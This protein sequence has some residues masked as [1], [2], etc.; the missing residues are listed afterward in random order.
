MPFCSS[1]PK[2]DAKRTQ[3]PKTKLPTLDSMDAPI[4]LEPIALEPIALEPI[5]LEPVPTAPLTAVT[6][7]QSGRPVQ[8]VKRA[9]PTPDATS[10]TAPAPVPAPALAPAAEPAVEPDAHDAS[11]WDSS[12]D[13]DEAI[14]LVPSSTVA[15]AVAPNRV[16][17]LALAASNPPPAAAEPD[18]HDPS[19]WD[20][21]S[22]DGDDALVSTKAV[23][24]A[25]VAIDRLALARGAANIDSRNRVRSGHS[26][27]LCARPK[28]IAG[29]QSDCEFAPGVGC[30]LPKAI[31]GASYRGKLRKLKCTT[32]QQ[33]VHRFTG[34]R[35]NSCSTNE[36]EAV[37]Y[38]FFRNYSGH[39]L[40]IEKLRERLLLDTQTAA[41]A[42]MCTWQSVV[43][44]KEINE[45]G[46]PPAPE[47]G[48][49]PDRSASIKWDY[50]AE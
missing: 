12:S 18:A 25:P 37:D 31:G 21:S 20:S 26:E 34:A 38:I 44:L 10:A 30:T 28:A 16:A 22:D 43:G 13:D 3:P 27:S 5:A 46:T 39:S 36:C 11:N 35:W 19:S 45:W 15:M 8:P 24:A 50:Y 48:T 2:R 42:C 1:R 47:G 7:R 23:S 9:S 17:P 32:C 40:N 4:A 41:Y 29:L 14:A 49:G 33:V 6:N